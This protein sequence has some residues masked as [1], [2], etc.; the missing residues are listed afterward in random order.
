MSIKALGCCV[1]ETVTGFQRGPDADRD[2]K[3][4][5]KAAQETQGALE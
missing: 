2:R 3:G 1:W 4:T 5:I